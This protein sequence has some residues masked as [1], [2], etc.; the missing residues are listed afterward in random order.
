MPVPPHT[1]PVSSV[2]CYLATFQLEELGFQ[3]FC[4]IVKSQPADKMHKVTGPT[5]TPDP[6][7]SSL[8]RSEGKG[9]PTLAS[10]LPGSSNRETLLGLS[11]LEQARPLCLCPARCSLS[12]EFE[13][14]PH[15]PSG[16]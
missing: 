12:K 6:A 15:G 1:H 16:W 7:R 8:L 10:H 9:R 4:N 2:I 13:S 11:C 14:H 3:L 5:R